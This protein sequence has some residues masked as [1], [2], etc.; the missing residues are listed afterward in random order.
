MNSTYGIRRQLDTLKSKEFHKEKA[1][2]DLKITEQ[3]FLDSVG[4]KTSAALNF[5][6]REKTFKDLV[7]VEVDLEKEIEKAAP[8]RTTYETVRSKSEDEIPEDIMSFWTPDLVTETAKLDYDEDVDSALFE[9][10]VCEG[11]S[12]FLTEFYLCKEINSQLR[13]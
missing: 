7:T 9:P 11:S 6:R 8:K 1:M 2:K 10:D 3:T 13:W 5:K 4:E 12:E